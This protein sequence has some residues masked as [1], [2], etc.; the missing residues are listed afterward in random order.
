MADGTKKMRKTGSLVLP[1][2]LLSGCGRAP[3]QGRGE[4]VQQKAS[5]I[6]LTLSSAGKAYPQ[7]ASVPIKATVKNQSKRNLTVPNGAR[8]VENEFLS[9]LELAVRDQHGA[10]FR[11][12]TP[13][14]DAVPA[15]AA[16]FSELKPGESL[17]ISFDIAEFL[18]EKPNAGGARK[19]SERSGKY[20]VCARLSSRHRGYY[21]PAPEFKLI[22]NVWTGKSG[23][24]ELQIVIK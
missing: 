2:I 16:H 20:T 15:R 19:L 14:M 17:D 13:P 4:D 8:W 12:L 24:S 22:E 11:P 21:D 5:E 10:R 6:L 18:A 7:G 23:W 1:L 9:G 3:T